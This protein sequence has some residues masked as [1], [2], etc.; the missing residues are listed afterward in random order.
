[1]IGLAVVLFAST[2]TDDIFILMMFFA[3]KSF[4]P[5][6]VVFGQYLGIALIVGISAL[7]TL[8][9]LL[10][11]PS[12]I[13]LMGFLPLSIGLKKL[14][15]LYQDSRETAETHQAEQAVSTPKGYGR[16]LAITAVTFSNSGDNIS[17]YVPFSPTAIPS[18]QQRL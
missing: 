6:Q 15:N 3:D 7:G 18:P 5:R 1:M 16:A 13:G 2:N 12:V 9:A 8:A 4:S 14:W 11:P 17:V 10:F